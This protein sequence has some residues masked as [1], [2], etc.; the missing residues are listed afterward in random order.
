MAT[1]LMTAKLNDIDPQAWLADVLARIADTHY[2]KHQ[3]AEGNVSETFTGTGRWTEDLN[4]QI[5]ENAQRAAQDGSAPKVAAK[6]SAYIEAV[7]NGTLKTYDMSTMGV[8]AT[9]TVYSSNR[10]SGAD[11]KVDGMGAFIEKNVIIKDGEMFDKATG[12]NASISQSGTQFLYS[13]W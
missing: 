12:K 2:A 1:L 4:E 13:V 11:I 9:M 5:L 6:A 10:G 7:N 3:D 8:A